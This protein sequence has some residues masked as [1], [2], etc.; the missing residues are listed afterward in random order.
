MYNQLLVLAKDTNAPLRFRSGVSLH[1]HTRHSRESLGFIGQF[2]HR[3]SAL[4]A[5]IAAQKDYCRCTSGIS[6]DFDRAYWTPPLCERLAHEVEA[7]QIRNLG[8]RPLVSLSDHD[9]I[10]ACLLLHRQPE[11]RD[12]PISTEWTIPWGSA[13]FH[14]GIHNLPPAHAPALMSEMAD[15]T[16]SADESRI[17]AL[18]AALHAIPEVLIVFNHPLWNFVRIPADRFSF[19]LS[20]FLQASQPFLHAFELNGMR[21]HRENQGVLRLARRHNQL[22]LSGG[23]RHG[24]EPNASLNLTNA[25]DLSEFVDEV[26]NG[27]QSTVLL[28]P[29]Y[30]EPLAW[31]FWQNFTHVIADYP[32]HPEGRRRWDERTFHPDRDGNIVPMS[33]LWRVGPPE[34]LRTVFAAAL[35]ATRLPVRRLLGRWRAQATEALAL[36]HAVAPPLPLAPRAAFRPVPLDSMVDDVLCSAAELAAD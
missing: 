16:A 10:D 31:R 29:Q 32:G 3:H 27:R 8:L 21:S 33:R 18:F 26:R 13:V 34:F 2:L 9:T 4:R 15:T 6:L 7:R 30:N 24:C 35:L 28:M 20:R 5:W 17:L 36:D 14:L 22:I 19:E 23:D 11:F 25:A 1:G 12:V